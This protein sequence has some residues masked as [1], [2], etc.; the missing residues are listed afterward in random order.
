MPAVLLGCWE[1]EKMRA[2]AALICSPTAAGP[3]A[4][5]V[6]TLGRPGQAC[7]AQAWWRAPAGVF[8]GWRASALQ[9]IF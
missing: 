7:E 3:E 6:P 1:G 9:L 4:R 2:R 5:P 8:E